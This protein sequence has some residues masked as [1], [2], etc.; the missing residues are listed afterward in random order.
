MNHR[1]WSMEQLSFYLKTEQ[2]QRKK[3]LQIYYLRVITQQLS[4]YNKIYLIGWAMNMQYIWRCTYGVAESIYKYPLKNLIFNSLSFFI[5]SSS[6]CE[7]RSIKSTFINSL[8]KNMAG[9]L[10]FSFSRL[11]NALPKQTECYSH[12]FKVSYFS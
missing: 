12:L 9:V 6:F 11:T 4:K 5:T 1:K 3:N 2:F 8:L 7:N 10:H